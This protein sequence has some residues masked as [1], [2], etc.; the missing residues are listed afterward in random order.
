MPSTDAF[1]LSHLGLNDFLF[2][3]VGTEANGMTLSLI[4]VFARR[5]DD[6]WREAGRLAG[7]PKLAA[8][9]SLA[10]TIVGMPTGK[11]KLPDA[12]AIATRLIALLPAQSWKSG[13][14][15]PT[16]RYSANAGRFVRIGLVL[17]CI[18]CTAAL[19]TGV[20]TRMDPPKLDGSDVASFAMPPR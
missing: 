1:A 3:P 7:L 19:A 9:E 18:A 13:H 11:W 20:F 10:G 15:L 17:L 12:M 16:S 8:I 6:P 14:T 5:G 2:A 4:S